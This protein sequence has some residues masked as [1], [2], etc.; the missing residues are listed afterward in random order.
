VELAPTTT[1]AEY[2]AA[3]YGT[4]VS[5]LPRTSYVG[6]TGSGLTQIV[7]NNPNRIFLGIQVITFGSCTIGPPKGGSGFVGW[8][9]QGAGGSIAISVDED[10][11]LPTFEFFG[12]PVDDR[13]NLTVTE[14]VLQKSAPLDLVGA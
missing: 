3:K 6:L 13:A 7:Q 9:L 12:V 11:P 2:L 4:Q 1:L 10:G 5:V 8:L 14:I